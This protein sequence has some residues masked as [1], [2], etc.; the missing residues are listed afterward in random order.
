MSLHR[1]EACKAHRLIPV[2]FAHDILASADEPKQVVAAPPGDT[3]GSLLLLSGGRRSGGTSHHGFMLLRK[4]DFTTNDLYCHR[5]HC[6]S[7]AT[8]PAGKF[9]SVGEPLSHPEDRLP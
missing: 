2:G 3:D 7:V 9:E 8:A 1:R 6:R 4:P 5:I